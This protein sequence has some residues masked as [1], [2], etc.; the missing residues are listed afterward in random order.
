MSGLSWSTVSFFLTLC[1]LVQLYAAVEA[2]VYYYI[3]FDIDFMLTWDTHRDV[4]VSNF[5]R[6]QYVEKNCIY[7]PIKNLVRT[8]P[9]VCSHRSFPVLFRWRNPYLKETYLYTIH[10]SRKNWKRRKYY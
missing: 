8:K 6:A 9:D 4:I 10:V 7:Q 2:S 5:V 3:E 1:E